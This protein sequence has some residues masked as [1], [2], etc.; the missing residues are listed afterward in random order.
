VVGSGSSAH[1]YVAEQEPGLIRHVDV[2][3]DAVTTLAGSGPGCNTDGIGTGAS[4][5]GAV[6]GCTLG[7]DGNLYI[8]DQDNLTVRKI[9]LPGAVVTTI[10]GNPALGCVAT[11]DNAAGC[12]TA[13]HFGDIGQCGVSSG[14]IVYVADRN[15]GDI[16]RGIPPAITQVVQIDF[17]GGASDT[18]ASFTLQHSSN[19]VS[20][21]TDVAATFTQ[22]GAGSFRATI[23]PSGA[24]Q[25]YRV[26]HN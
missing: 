21:Y 24:V 1:L 23:A 19:V 20:G 4:F 18:T 22:L 16:K 3:G 7:A 15:F 9:T 5:S 10:G 25:F 11:Y 26:K 6:S 8:A 12:G 2:G 13:G 17:T 14:G